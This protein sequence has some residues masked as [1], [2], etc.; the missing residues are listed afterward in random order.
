MID[1]LTALPRDE[2]AAPWN[3]SGTLDEAAGKVRDWVGPVPRW[4][5]L[6]KAAACRKEGAELKRFP[7][8]GGSAG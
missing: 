3:G 8:P 7:T 4:A 2:F 1:E 6:A 5:V